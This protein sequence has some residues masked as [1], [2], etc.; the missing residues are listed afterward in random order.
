MHATPRSAAASGSPSARA[1]APPRWY[2]LALAALLAL[3]PGAATADTVRGPYLGLRLGGH[4]FLDAD[5]G[6]GLD[7]TEQHS[8][9]GISVGVDV[10]RHLGLEVAADFFEPDLRA[11]AQRRSGLGSV[12]ELGMATVLPQLRLRYP[13]LDDRLVPYLVGGV[14]ASFTQFNNRKR[15][16]FNRSIHAEDGALAWT[17]GAGVEYFVASNVAVGAE[18]RF[19]DRGTH[20]IEV[21]GDTRRARLDS[22]LV[23]VAARVY[24]RDGESARFDAGPP[25]RAAFLAVRA[26]GARLVNRRIAPGIDTDPDNS[27]LLPGLNNVLGFTVGLD[28]GRTVAVELAGDGYEV[29]LSLPGVGTIGEYAITSFLPQLRLRY[30][31]LDGRLLPSLVLGVGATFTEFND[32]K[33][34]ADTMVV[35]G[36]DLSPAGVLGLGIEYLIARN[37]GLGVDVRYVI[38]RGHHIRI[39][40]AR[41]RVNLDTVN[42][43]AGLRL[44]FP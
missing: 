35:S 24:L 28:L 26:G 6:A 25:R 7:I 1:L 27:E 43:T 22:V 41:E 44:R 11:S 23:A 19:V 34:P 3:L 39:D 40:A 31:M 42:V 29:N 18:A 14:G 17:V 36:S 10:G 20:D 8:L 15:D 9:Y 33:P 13:L 2:R 16:G 32:R 37:L 21:D 30:P 12:G 38:S 5:V 4:L